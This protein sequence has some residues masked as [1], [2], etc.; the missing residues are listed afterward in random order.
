M[1]GQPGGGEPEPYR[2][3]R[4]G[5]PG[6]GPEPVP[7][8]PSRWL[9]RIVGV[10]LGLL[11]GLAVIVVFVFKGSEDTID[12]PR[13]SGIDSGPAGGSGEPRPGL[14]L[15]GARVPLVRV[16]H[17]APPPSGPVRLDFKQGRAARFVLDSDAGIAIAIPG[18]GVN[19]EVDAG[20]TLIA[21]RASRPGQ[22]PVVVA[23]SHIDI[24]TLRVARR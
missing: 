17:G 13:I 2:P 19:R 1:Q 4:V 12:A 5:P 7:R 23:S 20:R 3:R 11:L 22:Y 21:F 16:I 24:A 15:G 9:E 14:P 10:L 6:P 8:R 18:Y